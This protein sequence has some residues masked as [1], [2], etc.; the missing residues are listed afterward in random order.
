MQHCACEH[1]LC[2]RPY[3]QAL[4]QHCQI[5]L[6]AH[7]HS[8]ALHR[9]QVRCRASQTSAGFVSSRPSLHC[10]NCN[11]IKVIWSCVHERHCLDIA[12]YLLVTHHS[13]CHNTQPSATLHVLTHATAAPCGMELLQS[14]F[15]F[16]AYGT[17]TNCV[18]QFIEASWCVLPTACC[19]IGPLCST[20][21]AYAHPLVLPSGLVEYCMHLLVHNARMNSNT[22]L[23]SLQICS[24]DPVTANCLANS[25]A[26][27]CI[28]Q[29]YRI[30]W[31]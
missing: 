17:T 6:L 16:H 3:H 22:E 19:G 31:V 10:S 8:Y 26:M 21:V 30:L 18:P 20:A 1:S 28:C 5:L 7:H 2:L 12:L 9:P 23:Y 13:E 4:K 24:R 25:K 14:R 15:N 27:A 29:G 11:W